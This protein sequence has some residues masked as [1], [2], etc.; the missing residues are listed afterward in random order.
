MSRKINVIALSGS[1]RHESF[2]TRLLDAAGE[3]APPGMAI[4]PFSLREIPLFDQDKEQQ[5][6]AAVVDLKRRI[7]A[8]DAVLF[9]TPEYNYS[10]SGVL[11]NAIDQASRPYGDS[12]WAGKPCA[13]L[14]ASVGGSG[15]MRAQ[16][17]LRQVLVYL[18]MHALNHPEVFVRNAGELFDVAGPLKDD[19]TRKQIR[20]QLDA[21]AKL[22]EMMRVSGG[23]SAAA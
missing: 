14:G 13:I 10:F 12:A 1:L 11:K 18:D 8:A 5:P 20:K 15:T 22:V 16:Y 23:F 2:N 7:R 21:L 19:A 9:A 17:H 4:E 6:V 3:L